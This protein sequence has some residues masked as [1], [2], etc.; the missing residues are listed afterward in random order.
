M[1]LASHPTIDTRGGDLEQPWALEETMGALADGVVDGVGGCC[2]DDM[3]SVDGE[4]VTMT[5]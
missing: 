4:Q 2:T 1:R 3:A 5:F